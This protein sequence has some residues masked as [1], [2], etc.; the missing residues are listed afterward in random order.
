V[1]GAESATLRPRHRRGAKLAGFIAVALFW[2]GI[3]LLFLNDILSVARRESFPWFLALFLVPF[4]VVGVGLVVL[5]VRQALQLSNPR[6]I[7][8]V[9]KPIVALGDELRVDWSMKGRVGKLSRF[10][11]ALEARE[12]ATYMRGTDRKTDTN[13]FATIPLAN[14]TPPQIAGAGSASVKIPADTMHSFDA[15]YNKIVWVVRVR[16]EVP[17]WPD[18]DDEFPFTVGPRGR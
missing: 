3:L 4:V 1:P 8:T 2:N 18:S 5:A 6:P 14:Q 13:I 10:S 12:E 16:G 9:N 17:S 11:I 15:T 7:V